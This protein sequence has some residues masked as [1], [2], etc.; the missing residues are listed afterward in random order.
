MFDPIGH[1]ILISKSYEA[2]ANQYPK[3][4]RSNKVNPQFYSLP[5]IYYFL[6][7]LIWRKVLIPCLNVANLNYH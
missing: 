6:R 1:A 3:I 4:S 5:Y 7:D 2:S